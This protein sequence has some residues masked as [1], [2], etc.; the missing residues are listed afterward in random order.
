MPALRRSV[1]AGER[2]AIVGA[3]GAGKSTLLRLIA[4]LLEPSG[5]STRVVNRDSRITVCNVPG[6]AKVILPSDHFTNSTECDSV[7][8]GY[9]RL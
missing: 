8:T 9:G 6:P 4:G 1:R 5:H 2:I 3:N 7:P